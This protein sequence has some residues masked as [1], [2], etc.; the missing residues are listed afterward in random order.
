MRTITK[1]TAKINNLSAK[2]SPVRIGIVGGGQLGRMLTLAAKKLGFY[3]LI[4]DPTPQSPAGQV[5]DEQIVGD[6][7]DEA[8]IRQLAQ[9]SDIVTFESE[10]IND[11]VLQELLNEG[12][13]VDPSPKTLTIIKDKLRQKEYLK[14]HGIPTADF[15]EVETK[16]DIIAASE[17]F[18]YPLLLKARFDA[19][20][21]KGNAVIHTEDEIQ[22]GMEKLHGKKLYV[23]QYVPFI[24]ELAVMVIRDR[25]GNV[26]SYP[27]VETMHKDNICDVVLA[28]PRVSETAK[29]NAAALANKTVQY[30]EGAGIFGIEMFCKKDDNVLVNEIAPR[31]HNSGHYTIEASKTSQ[32]EQHIRAIAG[33]PLGETTMAVK[34]VAMKN[35]LGQRHGPGTPLGLDKATAL[36]NVSLHMYG[37]KESRVGRK[38]GH[39][40]VIGENVEECLD[41][42]EKARNMIII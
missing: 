29:K 27:I 37:K 39:I 25:Q 32:F 7:K 14:T 31:V 28:P 33:L 20:D 34:A 15:I 23:E 3:V 8:A 42:A 24:K 10:F 36:P 35:I 17:N 5:S 38:M 12:K 16:K 21:G 30:L 18:G 4:L 22:Q 11:K 19:Y 40:T 41:K 9:K 2:N 1:N 13:Q 6:F 26:T